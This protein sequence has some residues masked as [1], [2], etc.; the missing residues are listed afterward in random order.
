MISFFNSAIN[1]LNVNYSKTKKNRPA[2]RRSAP[3]RTSTGGGG[4]IPQDPNKGKI[5]EIILNFIGKYIIHWRTPFIVLTS[6]SVFKIMSYVSG[7]EDFLEKKFGQGQKMGN[8]TAENVLGGDDKKNPSP[9]PSPSPT[10]QSGRPSGL[11]PSKIKR[12]G[13]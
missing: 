13:W 7:I 10:E 1:E 6:F 11:N 4:K 3:R 2:V 8:K 9:S 12:K 5:L